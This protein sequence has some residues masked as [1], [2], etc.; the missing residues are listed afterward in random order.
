MT[1]KLNVAPMKVKMS[2]LSG[3]T[4]DWKMLTLARPKTKIDEQFFAK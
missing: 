1:I 3:V 4:I 2:D